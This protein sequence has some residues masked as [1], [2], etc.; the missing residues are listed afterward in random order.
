MKVKAALVQMHCGEDRDQNLEKTITMVE[1]AAK[2]GARIVCLQEVFNSIYFPQYID[3]K[4]Y[5]WA[6]PI[7]GPTTQRL[8]ET[9]KKNE[10]VLIAPIYEMAMTGVYYNTAAVID[11]EGKILGIYRKNHI[12]DLPCFHEKFYFKPGN[13]GYPVF[14]TEFGNI[15]VY[16]CYDRHFPEGPR[17]F[18]LNG[19]DMIF[20]PTATK[21]S[22]K[23]LWEIE[24]KG[25]AVANGIY[26][27]GV[28]RVGQEDA[29]D[30]YGCSFF[31]NP[32]GEIISQVG[33]KDDAVA[34]AEIDFDL[35]KEVRHMWQFFRDRR[36]ETYFPVAQLLP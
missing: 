32:K 36:P 33:D 4:Y 19:A 8:Q 3:S 35:I 17:I 21:G 28:N 6:E 34:L 25:H 30:F 27:G 24:L 16:I 26:V 14:H 2:D 22:Y 13:L 15:A 7:P 9:A 31:C 23:Y 18:G 5:N 1:K 29:M 20:I 10:I 12:P 11:H